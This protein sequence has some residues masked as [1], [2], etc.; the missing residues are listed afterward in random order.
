[1]SRSRAKTP[2]VQLLKVDGL[3]APVEV[4]RHPTARR[5]TLRVS[6]SAR[7][8]VLTI[9]RYTDVR[10][11]DRFLTKSLDWIR[12]RL[13]CVPDAV[14]FE[15][16]SVV[17]LRGIAHSVAFAGRRRGHAVVEI[18]RGRLGILPK[19]VVSGAEEHCA[20]R[21]RDWLVGES[22]RD[23]DERVTFHAR[24]LGL[25][26]KRISVRDQKSRWGSC[27]SDG[28]LSFSWRLVL[29]PPLVLDYVAAHEVAHLAEMNHGPRFWTLV[30]RTMPELEEAKL[31]L[32]MNGMQLYR[33][34]A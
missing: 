8:V 17:P 7:N 14:P 2:L 20:R 29:A 13:E 3:P 24:Q 25:V 6:H 27:T 11:A 1:M 10:E 23:L 30:K 18:E 32:R 5:L 19:L 33:Y 9:P 28:Q 4:R 31:W 34:G 22:R 21:L 15:D 16:G 26:A 12:E